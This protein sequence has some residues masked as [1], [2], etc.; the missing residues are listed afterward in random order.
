M[1]EKSFTDLSRYEKS[2]SPGVSVFRLLAWYYINIFF[3]KSDLFPFNKLKIILLRTFGAKVESN[4]VIKPNANIK[5]PW[6]L[7]IGENTWIG[8][9]VWIDN[10]GKVEIGRNC[11]ISQGA[12]ILCGNHNYLKSTFDLIVGDIILEDGVWIGAKSVVCPGVKCCSHSVLCVNSVATKD[13]ESFGIYQGNPANFI[14][15]RFIEH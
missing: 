10:L 3:F 2:Y 12:L 7:S 15:K 8:E 6:N 14:R 9:N 5:Y 11:C 13:L 4:V 1:I